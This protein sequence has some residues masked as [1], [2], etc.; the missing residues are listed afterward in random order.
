MY[1]LLND[2]LKFTLKGLGAWLVD[3]E[4]KRVM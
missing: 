4:N 3:R 2:G 1:V